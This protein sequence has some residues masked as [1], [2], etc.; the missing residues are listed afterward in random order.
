[1]FIQ[2]IQEN[3]AELNRNIILVRQT[4][5]IAYFLYISLTAMSKNIVW[6]VAHT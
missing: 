1:M 6:D 5:L 4:E 3:T 2:G